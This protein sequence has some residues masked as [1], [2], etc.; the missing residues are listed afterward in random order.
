MTLVKPAT[1]QLQRIE[2]LPALPSPNPH[3]TAPQHLATPHE[4]RHQ[5]VMG[6][7]FLFFI[8]FFLFFQFFFL[9]SFSAIGFFTS[10]KPVYF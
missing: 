9:I 2:P 10:K 5:P 7:F 3:H 8:T 4:R 6:S 1:K